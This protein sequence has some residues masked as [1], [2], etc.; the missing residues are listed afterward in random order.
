MELYCLF[1]FTVLLT[2]CLVEISC[3]PSNNESTVLQEGISTKEPKAIADKVDGSIYYQAD[4]DI[5]VPED[6]TKEIVEKIKAINSVLNKPRRPQLNFN[7]PYNENV[8][9]I[10][11]ET[12][13]KIKQII[14]SEKL[15][16]Y[17]KTKNEPDSTDSY[18][19]DRNPYSRAFRVM[20]NTGYPNTVPMPMMPYYYPYVI[21]YPVMVTPYAY[22]NN[23]LFTDYAAYNDIKP[24]APGDL[25]SVIPKGGYQTREEQQPLFPGFPSFPSFSFDNL[26]QFRPFSQLFPVLIKNPFVAFAQ[27]GGWENFIEY[28]QS[29]D[30]CSR[31]QKSAD[32]EYSEVI[33]KFLESNANLEQYNNQASESN[34]ISEVNNNSRESRALRKRTIQSGT[35]EQELKTETSKNSQKT[36]TRKTTKKPLN[37]EQSEDLKSDAE[38]SLRFPF[39][40]NFPWLRDRRPSSIPSP[41]FFINTLRVRK[42]GVAIAGPGGVA[43]AGRGGTAI[44]GPGGLAYTK[45]GGLAIAGPQAR[46]VAVSPEHNFND[47]VTRA[48]KLGDKSRASQP[49][50]EGKLVENIRK[51]RQG[52]VN[53]VYNYDG[54]K[55]VQNLYEDPMYVLHLSPRASAISGDRGVAISNPIS[56]VV[57]RRGEVASIIHS[58]KATAVVGAGGVAHAEAVQY[59]PFYGG[60][61]GQYLEIRKDTKGAILSEKVVAE[62]SISNENIMKNTDDN[63]LSKVLAANLQNLRSLSTNVLKLHNLGRKTGTLGHQERI[64]FKNQLYSLGEAASNTIKLIDEIGEDVDVLFKRNATLSRQ[65]GD[66]DEDYVSEEGIS[67]DASNSGEVVDHST[68]AE[69]KPVGLAVIGESGLAASRPMATA[70]ASSGVAIASPVGTAIAGVDPMLL[71]INGFNFNLNHQKTYKINGKYY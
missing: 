29:A 37:I 48:I 54:D 18:D 68:I 69:A 49:I 45:P 47:L 8:N 53:D 19:D 50:R 2:C 6:N 52:I 61:K 9:G 36:Y 28:G 65:Y 23:Q 42:G 66:G 38:G 33:K 70:V 17:S 39:M 58:P 62:E 32:D 63:L 35:S 67:I 44:V 34:T 64:R 1:G 59:I 27:G 21:N 26:F 51:N 10:D 60:A 5:N 20:P 14:A 46:V 11:E 24:T 56:R 55:I 71:S 15:H 4:T 3:R 7:T 31:K 41:G 25:K 22:S 30:V 57:L 40:D 16:P 13:A 12:L 43:T